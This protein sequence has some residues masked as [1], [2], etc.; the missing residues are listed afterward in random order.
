MM[1]FQ[2]KE[3]VPTESS[4]WSLLLARISMS[5]KASIL[6]TVLPSKWFAQ[7]KKLTQAQANNNKIC[8]IWLNLNKVHNSCF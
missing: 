7:F 6:E 4:E 2:T 5:L 1:T 8:A 3:H